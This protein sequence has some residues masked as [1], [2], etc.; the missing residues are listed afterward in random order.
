MIVSQKF[1]WIV[2]CLFFS[3]LTG[4][5]DGID[6]TDLRSV[7]GIVLGQHIDSINTRGI[8]AKEFVFK[9][10][11]SYEDYNRNKVLKFVSSIFP[12]SHHDNLA[13]THPKTVYFNEVSTKT[14]L[15][16][17]ASGYYYF[18]VNNENKVTQVEIVLGNLAETSV[19]LFGKEVSVQVFKNT[20]TEVFL[21]SIMTLYQEKYGVPDDTAHLAEFEILSWNGKTPEKHI[22][23]HPNGALSYKW[24]LQWFDIEICEGF[25]DDDLK[26]SYYFKDFYKEGG[27]MDIVS[28]ELNQVSNKFFSKYGSEFL[29]PTN[30]FMKTAQYSAFLKESESLVTNQLQK[31]DCY[32]HASIKYTL[33]SKARKILFSGDESMINEDI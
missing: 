16:H 18:T 7:E 9:S 28:L 5:V 20:V 15:R 14:R 30:E 13:F 1:R 17:S 26:Y 2:I 27:V 8:E 31:S 19:P 3:L 12:D 23:I 10:V 32:K 4:C 21:E 25:K 29:S 11:D 6:S 33:N 22:A 24:H